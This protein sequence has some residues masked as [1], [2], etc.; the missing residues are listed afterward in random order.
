MI[1]IAYLLFL[2]QACSVT[3]C[4][5]INNNVINKNR[6]KKQCVFN[7]LSKVELDI[8]KYSNNP[9]K[10]RYIYPLVVN[11]D[12]EDDF[13]LFVDNSFCL[14]MGENYKKIAFKQNNNYY[15]L[16]N[17]KVDEENKNDYSSCKN[18]NTIK[19]IDNYDCIVNQLLTFPLTTTTSKKSTT[20][21]SSTSTTSTPIV[22]TSTTSTP[23]VSTTTTTSQNSTTTTTSQ[24]STTTTT[25]QN[26][27]TT[28]TTTSVV[29][30]TTI[31]QNSTTTTTTKPVVSTTT[32]PQNLLNFTANSSEST[33]NVNNNNNDLNNIIL[34]TSIIGGILIISIAMFV[35]KKRNNKNQNEQQTIFVNDTYE[36]NKIINTNSKRNND[37]EI[38]YDNNV[39]TNEFMDKEEVSEYD[40]PYLKVEPINNIIEEE[41]EV[42]YEI[43]IP[44]KVEE[45]EEVEENEKEDE[46]EKNMENKVKRYT[47]L[48]DHINDFASN[49]KINI[50]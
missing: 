36:T 17:F 47:D 13:K 40:N 21:T 45:V 26:S 31:P 25:S 22:S 37:K 38:I 49:N 7:E 24:N 44:N 23:I 28:T 18:I 50:I 1:R 30:T 3:F 41:V 16:V 2:F 27:T 34:S 48:H 46:L 42:N 39:N 12:F 29:S 35:Y 6:L 10:F 14:F 33:Q 15:K 8:K 9:S 20:L 5:K 4:D 19:V 43:P 32:I 11:Q